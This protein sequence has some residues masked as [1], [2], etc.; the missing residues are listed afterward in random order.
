MR[1]FVIA[2]AAINGTV[3]GS[4]QSTGGT[5]EFEAFPRD[6]EQ[7]WNV[8]PS[9]LYMK[10]VMTNI[11]YGTRI[12]SKDVTEDVTLNS[13]E[14]KIKAKKPSFQWD[15]GV[16]LGIGRFLPGN[17][18]WD[19]ALVGTYF[20]G[21]AKNH[22]KAN[23][24]EGQGI[25]P[26]YIPGFFELA[27]KGS[28]NWTLNYFTLDLK[29]GRLFKMTPNIVI[30][31]YAGIRSTFQYQ[32]YSAKYH[33]TI[34]LKG[35][36]RNTSIKNRMHNDFWGVGP[37]VG[38]QFSYFFQPKWTILGNL[39]ASFALGQQS[40]REK[41]LV[42]NADPDETTQFPTKSRDVLH[43]VR[44]GLGGNIGLG[45]EDWFQNNTIRFAPSV[46]FEGVIWF[47]MNQLWQTDEFITELRTRAIR[48]TGNLALM[49]L[50]F[51][52]QVDF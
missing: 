16:R 29:L 22:T 4:A 46:L 47:A 50:V 39:D 1:N 45:W 52:L 15:S 40:L 21:Q 19:I 17:A 25:F 34:D 51:D 6:Q 33:A 18:K 3:F 5:R 12:V 43:P 38:T 30:H 14:H 31:P 7:K 10:P 44:V 48:K 41:Q 35:P 11:D 37:M 13:F 8:E 23:I 27:D 36:I 28:V 26:T 24:E 42:V 32:D 20:Y 49:G 2:A 9:Y